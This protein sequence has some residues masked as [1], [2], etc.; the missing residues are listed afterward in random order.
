[1]KLL[2]KV[3]LFVFLCLGFDNAF[4]QA[5]SSPSSVAVGPMGTLYILGS[6][7]NN[8]Y[9]IQ[10]YNANGKWL[11]NI[12]GRMYKD[13]SYSPSQHFASLSGYILTNFDIAST[14]TG[15]AC[16][17]SEIHKRYIDNAN[18]SRTRSTLSDF[19]KNALEM[20]AKY[21]N[22]SPNMSSILAKILF[23]TAICVDSSGNIVAIGGNALYQSGRIGIIDPNDGHT[24]LAF[25]EFTRE[26]TPYGLW[27]P[28]G[29]AV[30]KE[31]SIYV[32]N[33]GPYCV[34]KFSS[35]GKFLAKWGR[36]GSEEGEFLNPMGIAVDPRNSDVYVLDNY[37][38]S[39]KFTWI[40]Q[41]RVQ[42]FT[43]DGKFI[44]KWG[45]HWG[46][47]WPIPTMSLKDRLFAAIFMSPGVLLPSIVKIPEIE[48]PA[49]IVV[50]SKGYVYVAER[51][52]YRINKFTS[53]G[54]RVK[55]WGKK[56]S[57]P[58]EFLFSV[59]GVP[60]GMAVDDQDNIYIVDEGNNRVQKF[61]PNGK[62]LMEIK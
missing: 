1:M 27:N 59:S 62:F 33:Q 12:N 16:S 52:N 35:D 3:V 9:G 41:M 46:L 60:I 21:F 38:K 14:T 40:D 8:Q 11:A 29:I 54:R 50:D 18:L 7:A 13:Y 48:E 36:R 47:R 10:K 49:G 23:P 56:G 20:M 15:F 53:N 58:G 24:I 28:R 45:E 25:G 44:K 55:R 6:K 30:D 51:Q 42:K 43:K 17:F 22:T 32:A 57:G 5:L 31:N 34:K 26:D 61:D 37:R 39:S 19:R 2:A 4:A